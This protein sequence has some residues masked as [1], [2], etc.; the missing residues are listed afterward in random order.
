[1][2]LLN[3]VD[4]VVA[5][6]KQLQNASDDDG[7]AWGTRETSERGAARGLRRLPRPSSSPLV[8]M[9]WSCTLRTSLRTYPKAHGPLD[10][11]DDNT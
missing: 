4:S 8:T 11:L 7:S 5:E 10:F 3:N 2:V 6:S 9:S 1:M